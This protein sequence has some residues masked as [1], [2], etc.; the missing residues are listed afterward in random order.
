MQ[1][2]TFLSLVGGALAA[3]STTVTFRLP[4]THQLPNPFGLPPSTHATLTAAGLRL[5]APLTTS[6]TFVFHNVS[7]GSYLVD[8]HCPTHAF[9][10]LRLDVSPS[11]TSG[12][13]SGTP[14]EG[15]K[16]QAWETYRGNDWDNK[17][18]VLPVLEGGVIEVTKV[19]GQKNYFSERSTFS[20]FSILKNPMILLGLVS[21]A[22]FLGMPYL[23]NNM[24]P[25]MRA[26]WEERQKSNP[27]NSLMGGGASGQPGAANPMANFDMAA[28]LAG[29]SSKKDNNGNGNGDSRPEDNGGNGGNGGKGGKES[30]KKR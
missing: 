24:D 15:L 3:A 25:E 29:S 12:T 16:V 9:P 5:S 18:E 20:V 1:L 22:I 14:T 8:I 11:S 30:R 4:A 23:V 6:N 13:S 21:M 28:F 10:P 19:L 27:M 2:F 17:G 7:T 26:E